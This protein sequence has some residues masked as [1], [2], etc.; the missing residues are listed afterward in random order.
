METKTG[1]FCLERIKES[2]GSQALHYKIL[3]GGLLRKAS[4]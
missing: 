1:L 3:K 2:I 4:F